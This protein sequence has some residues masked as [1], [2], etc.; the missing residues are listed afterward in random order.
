MTVIP[1]TGE[2]QQPGVG[3]APGLVADAL[4]GKHR[5]EVLHQFAGEL[6]GLH[7]GDARS[8]Q[9]FGGGACPAA[10]APDKVRR[11]PQ[12]VRNGL[13]DLLLSGFLLQQLP[14]AVPGLQVEGA[15]VHVT[16]RYQQP[17]RVAHPLALEQPDGVGGAHQ[18]VGPGNLLERVGCALFAQMMHQQQPD[19]TAV[20]QGFQRAHILVIAGV[21]AVVRVGGADL[22]QGVDDHQAGFGVLG[23]EFL[24]LEF[25][26][27]PDGAASGLEVQPA[28]NRILGQAEQTPLDAGIGIL[29][30]E[31]QHGLRLGGAAPDLAAPG[32]LQAKP[33][34]QP[35]FAC[36][37]GTGQQGKPGGQQ[38]GNQP[39]QAAAG[40]K[41][42]FQ[43]Q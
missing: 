36:L 21:S 2:A 42:E 41:V 7:P 32:Q 22:L 35:T 26:T 33:Q 23:Q 14:D 6:V 29:Q 31:V 40:W 9:Q 27:V 18:A 28:G 11:P 16:A 17:G 1:V 4:R 34:A 19:A 20:R 5:V 37:A 8:G 24:D 39:P 30:T 43:H 25:Q 15:A 13:P 38:A 12:I 3:G 10:G